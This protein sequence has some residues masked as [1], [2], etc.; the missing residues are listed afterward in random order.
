MGPSPHLA[1]SA[2]SWF[3][4]LSRRCPPPSPHP[5]RSM[6]VNQ[7]RRRHCGARQR[8]GS[9]RRCRPR[10]RRSCL[11]RQAP[12][13][14]SAA[15]VAANSPPP[16]AC[17]A[18]PTRTASRDPYRRS[19]RARCRPSSRKSRCRCSCLSPRHVLPPHVCAYSLRLFKCRE[20]NPSSA[21]TLPL[22]RLLLIPPPPSSPLPLSQW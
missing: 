22:L 10:R 5:L 3:V 7:H 15:P 13:P 14:P 11:S 19:R 8:Q 20:T 9:S 21:S 12:L 18:G 2:L 1:T 4:E 16:T 17:P 6:Q